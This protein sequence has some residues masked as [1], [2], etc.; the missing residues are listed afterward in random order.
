[1][2]MPAV[3]VLHDEVIIV[4]TFEVAPEP[5]ALLFRVWGNWMQ[6]PNPLWVARAKRDNELRIVQ[7]HRTQSVSVAG[8]AK[9]MPHRNSPNAQQS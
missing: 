2:A 6:V 3:T 7:F 8:E 1:M 9:V 4:L 5:P